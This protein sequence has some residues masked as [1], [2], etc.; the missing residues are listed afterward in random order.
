MAVSELSHAVFLQQ[1]H[2]GAKWSNAKNVIPTFPKFKPL[3]WADRTEVQ[4]FTDGL[5]PYSDFNFTSLHCWN[6]R[7]KMMVS[8]LHENLV[9]LFYDYITE[10]PFLTFIGKGDLEETALQLID[11]SQNHY[12]TGML[13]L[14]PESVATHLPE[15]EFT[16]VPDEDSHDYV[17]G[18][19]YLASFGGSNLSRSANVGVRHCEDNMNLYPHLTVKSFA[20]SELKTAEY[21]D[22]FKHWAKSRS[23]DHR[24]L[25]EYG[26]FELFLQNTEIQFDVVSIYDEAKLIAFAAYE[27][28]QSSYAVNHFLKAEKSYKGL[29]ERLHF[30]MGKN[31]QAKNIEYL[32]CEQDLGLPGLRQSKRKFKPVF[33]LKKF[34]IKLK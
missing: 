5:P 22:L 9:L 3:E 6:T 2:A 18:V 23:L 17:F 33:F 32:N 34:T 11:Y 10:K 20:Q 27:I 8:Q 1:F 16:I 4:H 31:L 7:K 28:L 19:P 14:I 21:I 25:N 29:S 30:E 13:K 26:A 15:K 12:Q 24:E